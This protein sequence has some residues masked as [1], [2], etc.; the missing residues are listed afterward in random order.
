MSATMGPI[1]ILLGVPAPRTRIVLVEDHA[2]LR[3]GLRALIEI[4]ADFEVTG[5]FACVAEGLAGIRR[6][7]PDIVLTD[8]AFP[9]SSGFELLSQIKHVAPCARKLVLTAHCSEAYIR[10]ALDAGADGYV[11]KDANRAELMRA[12]RTVAAGRQFLCEAVADKIEVGSFAGSELRPSPNTTPSITGREREILTRIARGES[13][14]DI[15]RALALSVKTIEKHRSNVM[16]KLHLH[17]TAAITL[18]AVRSGLTDYPQTG[19][20]FGADPHDMSAG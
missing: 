5:D 20:P 17:N 9:T 16:R 2:I 11:L 14:K 18:F 4:E 3:E 13:N 10:A 7:R 8:L 19:V 15:A 6:E 12:I 1:S